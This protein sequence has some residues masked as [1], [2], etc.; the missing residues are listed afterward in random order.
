MSFRQREARP[1]PTSLESH[2]WKFPLRL[3]LMS[4]KPS[5]CWLAISRRESWIRLPER[6]TNRE[7]STSTRRV[8][9][10]VESAAKR[11]TR[12]K[13]VHVRPY[14]TAECCNS[15]YSGGLTHS[16]LCIDHSYIPSCVPLKDFPTKDKMNHWSTDTSLICIMPNTP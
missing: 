15:M 16:L 10:P 7:L 6:R 5:F 4:K 9:L 3:I 2:S 1:W 13:E 8:A 11:N 14:L 12:D